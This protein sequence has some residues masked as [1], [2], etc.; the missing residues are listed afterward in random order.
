MIRAAIICPDQDLAAQLQEA[1]A[2]FR[3]V[4]VA[5]VL[6]QYPN[7]ARLPA[8]LR[9]ALP[10]LI[11]LSV[12]CLADAKEVA[13]SIETQLPGTPIV[14]VNRTSDGAAMLEIL[15][16]GAKDF[17]AL[18]FDMKNMEAMLRRVESLLAR[19]PESKMAEAPLFAFLP[20]K[21]GAGATTIAVNTSLAL[22]R[23]PDTRPLLIDLDLNSGL[24][25]FMLS[26]KPQFSVTDAAENAPDMDESLWARIVSSVGSLDV[27]PAGAPRTGFRIEDSQIRRILEFARRN[28]GAVSVDL[29]GM[30]E[31]YCLEVLRH[32]TQIFLVCTPEIASMHLA[33]AKLRDLRELDLEE[34]VSILLNRSENSHRSIPL[35]DM[36]DLF[37]KKVFLTLPNAYETT[38]Q[39]AVNGKPVVATSELGMSFTKLARIMIPSAEA[40]AQQRRGILD[41][42]RGQNRAEKKVKVDP[43]L[44]ASLG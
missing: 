43:P 3:N 33:C 22:A 44:A 32:T 27:L 24:V 41:L 9:A 4:G 7:D 23:T 10:D 34:R 37:K 29:S 11:F 18:P 42:F 35:S 2:A 38:R 14:A 28:Y 40:P 21:A 5:R 15:R 31:K 20:A 12:E 39:A 30:M 17:L 6:H 1:L 26:L 13:L 36:E 8:F 19:K 16:A 25:E